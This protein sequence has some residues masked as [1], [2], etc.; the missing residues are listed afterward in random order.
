MGRAN[1]RKRQKANRASMLSAPKRRKAFLQYLFRIGLPLFLIG[2]GVGLMLDTPSAWFWIGASAFFLGVI[3]L[4]YQIQHE[5]W[6]QGLQLMAEIGVDL[7]FA[8][9]FVLSVIWIFAPAPLVIRDEPRLP[10]YV[11][12]ADVWGI[13]WEPSFSE[14]DI[15]VE[16]DSDNDYLNVIIRVE[17]DLGI[18]QLHFQ[19]SPFRCTSVPDLPSATPTIRSITQI[20]RDETGQWHELEHAAGPSSDVPAWAY[21]VTCDKLPYHSQLD[22]VGALAPQNVGSTEQPTLLSPRTARWVKV[23]A[24]YNFRHS[25][26]IDRTDC[27]SGH[28]GRSMSVVDCADSFAPSGIYRTDPMETIRRLQ[29]DRQ[30]ETEEVMEIGAASYA[31]LIFWHPYCRF[32]SVWWPML[33]A[34][35]N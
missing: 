22:L 16:N 19:Q 10:K 17:T 18:Q 14:L 34:L 7:I 25:R 33:P 20:W 29:Q 1:R 4:A 13:K 32:C 11:V 9:I 5:K 12:G 21:R 35:R 31:V 3:L 2:L 8:V 27:F 6:F 26:A 24:R 30:E 28:L 15:H 23:D